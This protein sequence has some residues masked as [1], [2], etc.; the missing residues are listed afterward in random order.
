M[1][2]KKI[3]SDFVS[4][5]EWMWISLNFN[6]LLLEGCRI[7]IKVE[8]LSGSSLENYIVEGES[9]VYGWMIVGWVFWV[10]WDW[11]NFVWIY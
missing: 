10:G 4:S 11:W 6:D 2:E 7:C 9:F 8:D 5:G 3:I 1:E